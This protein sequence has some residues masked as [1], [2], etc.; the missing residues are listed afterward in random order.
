MNRKHLLTIVLLN[1]FASQLASQITGIDNLLKRKVTEKLSVYNNLSGPEKTYLQTDKDFYHPGDALWF[2]I[3][4][5]DGI[6]HK[7][8]NKSRLVYVQLLNPSDSIIVKQILYVE[9]TSSPG[10]IDL[11]KELEEGTY[12]L[13]AYSNYMLN[14]T[15]TSFYQKAIPILYDKA[16]YQQNNVL[17]KS[18]LNKTSS[19]TLEQVN[20]TAS[21]INVLFFPE[22]GTLVAGLPGVLGFKVTDDKGN[23]IPLKGKIYSTEGTVV[24]E[25]ESMAFGL[26]KVNFTPTA[27]TSYFATINHNGSEKR[28]RIPPIIAKGYSF[29]IRNRGGNVI[30]QMA[31][32]EKN[33]LDGTLLI[34]HLRG[35]LIFERFEKTNE[36]GTY[37]VKFF[38][39][40][41]PNG[42]AN[43]TLFSPNGAPILDRLVFIDNP[44]NNYKVSI[45]S[46]SPIFGTREKVKLTISLTDRKGKP[47]QGDFSVRVL[48]TNQESDNLDMEGWLM[49]NADLDETLEHPN[50]FF[51]NNNTDADFLM[52]ALMLNN[53]WSRP[54][55]KNIFKENKISKSAYM[56]EKGIML[57]GIVTEFQKSERPKKAVVT[58]SIMEDGFEEKQT[59][60]EKGRFSFG[61]YIFKDS[62]TAILQAVNEKTKSKNYSIILD[63]SQWPIV[64]GKFKKT[65]T[66]AQQSFKEINNTIEVPNSVAYALEE[67][68]SKVTKLS[69]VVVK[70]KRKTREQ[71]IE[72]E[73]D[74]LTS[75]GGQ[76]DKRIISALFP[77][78]QTLSVLDLLIRS[79]SVTILEG[80]VSLYGGAQGSINHQTEPLILLDGTPYSG[81]LR[82]I[83]AEDVLFIDILRFASSSFYG[84]RSSEGVIAIYSH[85]TLSSTSLSQLPAPGIANTKIKGFNKAREFYAP[86]YARDNTSQNLPDYR[87]T[88]FWNPTIEIDNKGRCTIAFY[89]GDLAGNYT[90]E[91]EG[92]ADDGKIIQGSYDFKVDNHN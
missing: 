63:D 38:T 59:T 44:S 17:F 36:E 58:L 64:P 16:S 50:F 75:Y 62:I 56:V 8:S 74:A 22:G 11:P 77:A 91:L 52:D 45:Q 24:T 20:S 7:K 76:P 65:K 41:L 32:T 92:I 46:D 6:T 1:L 89:T 40:E 68:K 85:R 82:L 54:T 19:L 81:E 33:G 28:F 27:D 86:D 83:R 29:N 14:D 90:V 60:D 9:N 35:D 13:R 2:K 69:E 39:K 79:G 23:G 37:A 49:L 42:I 80:R 25:F 15:V 67:S 73:M 12:S 48:P 10:T 72:E 78:R 61:P 34:G 5:I 4:L 71:L 53:E 26:G 21:D 3:Y 57:K 47:M 70:A 88:L 66:F 55:L 30:L 18:I 87:T 84:V 43:F 51:K 31:S